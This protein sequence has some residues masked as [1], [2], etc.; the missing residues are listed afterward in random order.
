MLPAA[1]DCDRRNAVV[2]GPRLHG[3]R[4]SPLVD[5]AATPSDHALCNGFSAPPNHTCA[6]AAG[7]P[8]VAA[9]PMC[10]GGCPGCKNN[11]ASISSRS[12]SLAA[13]HGLSQPAS[14]DWAVAAAA[15]AEPAAPSGGLASPHAP[16][17][18]TFVQRLMPPASCPVESRV[19]MDSGGN[20][21]PAPAAQRQQQQRQEEA[22]ALWAGQADDAAGP[23]AQAAGCGGEL[24]ACNGAGTATVANGTDAGTT[25]SYDSEIRATQSVAAAA[26]AATAAT[27]QPAGAAAEAA[28]AAIAAAAADSAAAA[29]SISTAATDTAIHTA[30]TAG[31]SRPHHH[32]I[33]NTDQDPESPAASAAAFAA[34]CAALPPGV[35]AYRQ[36][37]PLEYDAEET[38]A[39]LQQDIPVRVAACSLAGG[40]GKATN[41]GAYWVR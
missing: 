29:P 28:T 39:Y 11:R 2:C 40:A 14:H 6:A 36:V 4:I 35:S 3:H 26:A 30:V 33:S 12:R 38:A 37:R 5:C 32:L 25:A 7:A 8:A 20:R 41:N 27:S 19:H 15:A 16:H 22:R 31:G 1:A 18:D 9:G 23:T 34:Y 17:A 13:S 24:R 21:L 10:P